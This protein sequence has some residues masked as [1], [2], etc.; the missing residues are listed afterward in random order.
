VVIDDVERPES[1]TGLDQDQARAITVQAIRGAVGLI[2][3][4]ITTPEEEIS[5]T[6]LQTDAPPWV[7]RR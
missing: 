3:D 5:E 7:W 2:S 1:M 4:A 6:W